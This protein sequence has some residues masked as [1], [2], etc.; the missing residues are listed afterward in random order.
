M[1]I[2][3]IGDRIVARII[4]HRPRR[5]CRIRQGGFD[6]RWIVIWFRLSDR[7]RHAAKIANV[8]GRS[9]DTVVHRQMDHLPI[10]VYFP[11]DNDASMFVWAGEIADAFR[12]EICIQ[13]ANEDGG[14][15]R[16]G[17]T[18]RVMRHRVARR[19]HILGIE[20][21][22]IGAFDNRFRGNTGSFSRRL[23]CCGFLCGL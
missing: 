18:H 11:F 8:F 12:R 17:E 1:L 7:Q 20:F 15:K 4:T 16:P 14:A 21:E 9:H 3:F 13:S 22:P 10:V 5:G 2:D 19:C 6:F 23:R